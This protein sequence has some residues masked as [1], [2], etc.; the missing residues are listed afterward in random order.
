MNFSMNKVIYGCLAVAVF[1]AV[2]AASIMYFT[3]PKVGAACWSGEVKS[4][5]DGQPVVC[6]TGTWAVQKAQH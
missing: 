2:G 3:Q 6:A 5:S 4:T 1:V